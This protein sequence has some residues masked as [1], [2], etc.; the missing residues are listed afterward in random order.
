[1]LRTIPSFFPEVTGPAK[2]ALRISSELEK[3]DIVSPILTSDFR[4]KTSPDKE[5]VEGVRVQR[6]HDFGGYMQY[7]FIPGIVIPL[8]KEDYDLIHAHGYRNFMTDTAFLVSKLRSK[9]FVL[10]GHG[11]LG[12]YDKFLKKKY[13]YKLYDIST[14]KIV[15]KKANALIVSTNQEFNEGVEFGIDKAKIHVIPAGIDVSEYNR[16][17]VSRD[18]DRKRV[19]FV[20]RIWKLLKKDIPAGAASL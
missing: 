11:M 4:A 6:F 3:R 12:G 1:M 18:T 5:L 13:P 7:H 8:L 19:L 10:H 16:I 17:A 15:A 14:F 2:Q 9:P 20:G